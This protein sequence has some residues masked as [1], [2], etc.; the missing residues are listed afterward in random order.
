MSVRASSP[1]PVAP[2]PVAPRPVAPR[3]PPLGAG[4]ALPFAEALPARAAA[5][6]ATAAQAPPR[7]RRGVNT[8]PWFDLTREYPAPRTDYAWPPWQPDRAVPRPADLARLAAAGFD[9]I[10]IPV[11]PGPYLDA[12]PE[13]RRI[14]LDQLLGAVR[15]ADAAGLGSVVNLQPNEATHFW[16]SQTLIAAPMRP[17]S[18][19]T[20]PSSGRWREN[21]AGC[22]STVWRSNPSTSRHSNVSPASGAPSRWRCSRAPARP[23][24]GLPSSRPAVAAAWSAASKPWTLIRSALRAAAVHLPL[25]RALPVFP[26]GS[27]VDARTRVPIAERGALARVRRISRRYAGRRPGPDAGGR[28]GA[29]R[30]SSARSTG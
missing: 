11:D 6:E 29:P 4:L 16:T 12:D 3:R 27:A 30:R 23:R 1:R 18:R 8:W 13:R 9:F 10:R 5:L 22:G 26:S 24:P 19:P 15:M 17:S 25:L 7:F 20:G 21:S 14:L 28:Q 2:R